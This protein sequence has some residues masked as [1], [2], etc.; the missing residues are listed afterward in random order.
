M[1]KNDDLFQACLHALENGVPVQR[2]A[3]HLGRDD[4]ETRALVYLVAALRDL[5]HPNPLLA[6]ARARLYMLRTRLG[7]SRSNNHRGRA[8]EP[9]HFWLHTTG[10]SRIPV[11]AAAVVLAL[12]AVALLGAGLWQAGPRNA[13]AATLAEVSGQVQVASAGETSGWHTARDGERLRSGQRIH[14][15]PGSSATLIF[16]DGSQSTLQAGTDLILR[17]VEGGWGNLLHV[18]LDQQAGKTDHRVVPFGGKHSSFLVLTPGGTASVHGTRFRVAVVPQ[19]ASRFSVGSG[20]ILVANDRSQVYLEA[21]QAIAAQPGQGLESP[22][23]QFSLQG[24]LTAMEADAW[25]VAGVSFTGLSETVV[26]GDP[27]LG[28][29]VLVEGHIEQDGSWVADSL[30]PA[31]D[32]EGIHAFTGELQSMDGQTWQIG[33]SSLLVDESTQ[34]GDG[35]QVGVLAQVDFEVLAGDQWHALSIQPLENQEL[36]PTPTPT[37]DPAAEPVLAFEPDQ[38]EIATCESSVDLMAALSNTASDP[39]DYAAGVVL[40]TAVISGAE[41]VDLAEVVPS[42]W[43]RIEAGEQVEFDLYVDLASDWNALPDGTQVQVRAFIA[44]ET[45]TLEGHAADLRLNIVKDCQP[46]ETGSPTETLTATATTTATATLTPTQTITVTPTMTVPPEVT[47]MPVLISTAV[48]TCT[49]ADPHPAG[50]ELAEDLGVPYEE[51][52]GWFC[53]GFGFGN[54]KIAYGLSGDFG[55]PVEEVFAMK[56]GGMGWGRIRQALQSQSSAAAVPSA[57]ESPAAVEIPVPSATPVPSE[58]S[59]A[60]CAGREVQPAG[61]AVAQKY[62]KPYEEIIG[63]Y[64]AGFGFG[65]INQAYGLSLQYSRSVDEIFT[66]KSAGMKWGE[67]RQALAGN[68]KEKG[69]KQKP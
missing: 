60:S 4:G 39:S 18:V 29:S 27:Q 25:T 59:V 37:P 13:Q 26:S 2:L 57:T 17:R 69:K 48:S 50:A 14:T 23:Y 64:C 28:D 36:T 47:A 35:L 45:N 22:G 3:A 66:M 67:I 56:S 19:G 10:P 8:R 38:A 46:V 53:Q 7:P 34:L 55:V 54:I 40:D 63:W 20:V 68:S 33:G 15:G 43:D 9:A 6:N 49:G 32:G 61:Q 42:T 58:E 21:G 5:P 12:A 51:I 62:A 44:S 11:V 41:H 65:D 1:S 52:M 16:F 30:E 31:V 24:L